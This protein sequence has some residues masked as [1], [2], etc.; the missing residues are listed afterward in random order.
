MFLTD[1]TDSQETGVK[2]L[3]TKRCEEKKQK[4]KKSIGYNKCILHFDCKIENV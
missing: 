2:L 3:T 4:K 1:R